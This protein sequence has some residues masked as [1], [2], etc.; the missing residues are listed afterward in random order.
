MVG[1]VHFTHNMDEIGPAPDTR[2]IKIYDFK[3]PDKFSKGQIRAISIIHDTFARLTTDSLSA[4]LRS[5]GRVHVS[6]ERH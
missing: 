1:A 5:I 3:Q 4:Q 2:R 6:T